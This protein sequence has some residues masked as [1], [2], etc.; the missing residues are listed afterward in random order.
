MEINLPEGQG[1]AAV[2]SEKELVLVSEGGR[3]QP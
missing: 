3:L 1:W 2:T